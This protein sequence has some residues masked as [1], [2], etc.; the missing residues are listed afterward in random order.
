MNKTDELTDQEKAAQR[1]FLAEFDRD[2][3]AHRMRDLR[4]I[5]ELRQE[6]VANYLG[7]KRSSLGHMESV[8][9]YARVSPT[10][11]VMTRLAELAGVPST[12]VLDRNIG[13]GELRDR[14]FAKTDLHSAEGRNPPFLSIVKERMQRKL[15]ERTKR[16]ERQKKEDD[17]ANKVYKYS[18]LRAQYKAANTLKPFG[19]WLE[20]FSKEN[21]DAQILMPV[22]ASAEGHRKSDAV[23][24]DSSHR[25]AEEQADLQAMIEEDAKNLPPTPPQWPGDP[26]TLTEWVNSRKVFELP[27][28]SRDLLPFAQENGQTPESLNTRFWDA[29]R[30]EAELLEEKA[31]MLWNRTLGPTPI[32]IRVDVRSTRWVMEFDW[33]GASCDDAFF[34]EKSITHA[35]MKLTMADRLS[36]QNFSK[37]II[38]YDMTHLR[39]TRPALFFGARS[40]DDSPYEPY[41]GDEDHF[42]IDCCLA[43]IRALGRALNINIF[44]VSDPK[45]AALLIMQLLKGKVTKEQIQKLTGGVLLPNELEEANSENTPKAEE[46]ADAN[47][48]DEAEDKATDD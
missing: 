25:T 27:S 47:N 7:I 37:A 36:K 26:T 30:F 5:M 45:E 3:L 19:A 11:Q 8:A 28:P 4:D 10:A 24:A 31:N 1:A 23:A 14:I 48:A 33:T 41:Y 6:E 46:G 39:D 21:P 15:L 40:D 17:P 18:Y 35:I 20:D 34:N 32:E 16:K 42:P 9:E 2:W 44:L 12:V 22:A 29:V 13:I 38:L 43:T